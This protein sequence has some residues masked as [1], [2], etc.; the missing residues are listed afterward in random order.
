MNN[1]VKVDLIT[2]TT[3]GITRLDV[4]LT[5]RMEELAGEV[6]G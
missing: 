6:V 3:G 5:G 1:R 4:E 2:H